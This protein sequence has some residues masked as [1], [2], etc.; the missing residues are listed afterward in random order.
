MISSNLQY[1]IVTQRISMGEVEKERFPLQIILTSNII[2]KNKI[3]MR[4]MTKDNRQKEPQSPTD[5]R[6]FDL[7]NKEQEQIH[8]ELDDITDYAWH[9][10]EQVPR[11]A[12]AKY[13]YKLCCWLSTIDN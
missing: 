11:W 13:G 1:K 9:H 5:T 7:Q 8:K 6:V 10:V 12:H 4:R 2:S 3:P